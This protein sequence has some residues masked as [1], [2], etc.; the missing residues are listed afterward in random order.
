MTAHLDL[1]LIGELSRRFSAA[2]AELYA[3]TVEKALST[4]RIDRHADYPKLTMRTNG[5]PYF[6]TIGTYDDAAPRDYVA[7]YRSRGLLAAITGPPVD[8]SNF[9]KTA[10]LI[11]FANSHTELK[12]RFW[13]GDPDWHMKNVLFDCVERYISLYGLAPLESNHMRTVILPILRG[14]TDPKLPVTLVVPIALTKF[15]LDRFRLDSDTFVCRLSRPI[16]LSR[17]RLGVHGSGAVKDVVAGATHALV[18]TKWELENSTAIGVQQSL[19]DA[20]DQAIELIEEFFASLRLATNIDTGYAQVLFVPRAWSLGY[21]MDLPSLYG[22]TYRRYPNRFDHY[23]WAQDDIPTVSKAE[24]VEV[25]SAFQRLRARNEQKI[26]IAVK[27]LNSCLTRDDAVDAI[28]DATIGLEV[29]LGDRDNQALSYKLR[30]RAAAL[31]KLSGKHNPRQILSDIKSVY[32]SRSEIV[33]GIVRKATNKKIDQTKQRYEV[34]RDLATKQLRIVLDILIS[35]PRYLEPTHIDNELLV[36]F[37]A[38]PSHVS[39]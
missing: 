38:V 12:E 5:L 7:P 4:T 18:S 26:A 6:S 27:R 1:M 11:A 19:S 36:D 30:L 8:L 22:S 15:E 37:G 39:S 14:L 33:H 2:F 20:P 35:N 29:L 21:Y 23:R 9:A 25:K 24:I 31:A 34:Q 13:G 10:E 32:E 28:L 16:Q 3:A 17:S